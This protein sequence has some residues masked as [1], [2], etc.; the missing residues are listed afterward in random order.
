MTIAGYSR[1]PLKPVPKE[2]KLLDRLGERVCEL[3]ACARQIN[4]HKH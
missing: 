2:P 1:A 3:V 4:L